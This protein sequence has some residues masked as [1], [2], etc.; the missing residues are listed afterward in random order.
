MKIPTI[1]YYII[2]II[3]AFILFIVL[4]PGLLLNIPA[5]NDIGSFSP[6][7]NFRSNEVTLESSIVHAFVFCLLF[8]GVKYLIE[9]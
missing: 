2:Y 3:Y 4:S 9:K 5:S 8:F 6:Y 7:I 1:I